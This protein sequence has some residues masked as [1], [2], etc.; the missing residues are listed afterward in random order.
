MEQNT[1][2]LSTTGSAALSFITALLLFLITRSGDIQI[3]VKA[4]AHRTAAET[5]LIHRGLRR[6]IL[7]D[8]LVFVPASVLLGLL[9]V[10]PLVEPLAKPLDNRFVASATGLISYGFPFATVRALVVR[11]ALRAL[12]EFASV[13]HEELREDLEVAQKERAEAAANR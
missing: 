6:S 13:A 5:K 9:I 4:E 7:L 8:G 1:S 12:R 11:F 3:C 10:F 2:T